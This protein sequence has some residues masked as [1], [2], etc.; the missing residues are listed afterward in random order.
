MRTQMHRNKVW[1]DDAE[2]PLFSS[3]RWPASTIPGQ[4]LRHFRAKSEEK[5][6]MPVLRPLKTQNVPLNRIRD[7]DTSMRA[8][9][10]LR[11]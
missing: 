9:R 7:S 5:V 6:K 2:T 4:T 1:E 10:N 3:G 11:G 8:H